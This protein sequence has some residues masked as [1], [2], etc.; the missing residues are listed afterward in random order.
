VN[1]YLLHEQF[2]EYND[3]FY[4]HEFVN[5]ASEHGLKYLGDAAFH[6][7]LV[8][9]LPAEVASGI[10][11]ISQNQIA[12]EQYRD[13]VINRMFRKT[14]LCH[15]ELEVDRQIT[16]ATIRKFSFR[17]RIAASGPVR[18]WRI[19][20][21]GGLKVEVSDALVKDTLT[22]IQRAA[23]LALTF[24]ELR[25]RVRPDGSPEVDPEQLSSVLLSLY[26]LDAIDFR[27]WTPEMCAVISERP[28]AFEPARR[29]ANKPGIRV[30]LPLHGTVDLDPFVEAF[31]PLVD[32]TRTETELIDAVLSGIADKT[33]AVTD[34]D[35]ES[36][37]S[38]EDVERLVPEALE[39][40]RVTGLLVS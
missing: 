18:Q 4:L 21:T 13:F 9:D 16:S 7:M 12:L 11:E 10:N 14:L 35:P 20:K 2:S 8:N 3:A 40:L 37:P 32:G 6:T 36:M 27:T 25:E 15:E 30:P 24:E 23:P 31:L 29:S 34:V 1:S 28:D 19:V 39:E 5:A 38:R 26:S 22:A 33:F 17:Q